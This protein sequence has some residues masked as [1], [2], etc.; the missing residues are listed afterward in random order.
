MFNWTYCDRKSQLSEILTKP[1]NPRVVV[2]F[3]HLVKI[4]D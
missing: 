4:S 3:L 2:I 1:L